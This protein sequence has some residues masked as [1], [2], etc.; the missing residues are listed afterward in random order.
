MD[1]QLKTKKKL[2]E[3]FNKELNCAL[4]DK[5][6]INQQSAGHL[7]T[8]NI[9]IILSESNTGYARG[10]NIGIRFSISSGYTYSL[11]SNNDIITPNVDT[12]AKLEEFMDHDTMIGWVSPKIINI[13]GKT[14]GPFPQT[15]ISELFLKKGIFFPFWFFFHPK[16]RKFKI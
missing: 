13:S 1:L 9:Y 3:I 14:E 10:N 4:L 15:N 7:S 2:F 16:K 12:I 8:N 6:N 5:T 11:I